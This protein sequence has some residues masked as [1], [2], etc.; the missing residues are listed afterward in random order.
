MGNKY[1]YQCFEKQLLEGRNDVTMVVLFGGMNS[2]NPKAYMDM[3]VHDY[4]VKHGNPMYNEFVEI[5][6]D[7]PWLR[8]IIVGINDLPYK[9]CSINA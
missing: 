6:L 3:A 5:H 4:L 7:N 2:Q 1:A 8:V 9:E